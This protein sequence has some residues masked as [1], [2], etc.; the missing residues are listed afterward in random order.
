[1]KHAFSI[2]LVILSMVL[3]TCAA[4]PN[5]SPYS[6]ISQKNAFRL[7][8][9]VPEIETTKPVPRPQVQLL[10]VATISPRPQVFLKVL[11][12]GNPP[13]PV[14]ELNVVLNVGESASGVQVLSANVQTGSVLL[15]N[16]GIE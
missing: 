9:R 4:T 12:P 10:G 5:A 15:D 2:L 11:P 8:L 6:H 3:A 16:N 13:E 14:P 1:M 7:D